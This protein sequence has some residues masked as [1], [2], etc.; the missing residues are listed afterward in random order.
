MNQSLTEQDWIEYEDFL[1]K[2]INKYYLSRNRP[3]LAESE[4]EKVFSMFRQDHYSVEFI[5][6]SYDLC[7]QAN[8]D[9]DDGLISC[10]S[11]NNYYSKEIS[12][13]P[14]NLE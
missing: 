9:L 14:N 12:K 8:I 1:I 5:I 4:L 13:L 6:D 11:L 3:D 2:T 10:M 7:N